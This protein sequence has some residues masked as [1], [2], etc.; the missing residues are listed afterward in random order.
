MS[1]TP[2]PPVSHGSTPSRMTW[3]DAMRGFA[4]LLVMFTHTYTMPQGLDAAFS[5][6][7]FANVA[8]VFQ[9][10]RMPMLMFLSGVLLP[11]SVS[12]PLGTYYRG[13]AERILWPFLVWMVV[14][15]LATGG[16][17]SLLSIEFWRGGAWHLWFLW[18]LMLCYLIGPVIRRVP[19]LV[20]A[21]VLFVLLLEFVS[22]PRH[23]V[24]PL[25][26]GVYFFLGAASAR[27]LPRIRTSPA[28]LGVIAVILM[29]LTVTATRA[30]ALVVA[31]RQPWSVFAALPGIL[32]VLWL[33]PR[34]PRLPFLEF[35]G[36]RSMVLYVAHM[37]VLILAVAAFRD[38]AAVRPVDFYVAIASFT[39]LVPLALALG[40]RRVRWLF[41]FPTAGRVRA[42]P[43]T[44]AS[45][46]EAADTVP[47]RTAEPAPTTAP[48]SVVEPAPEPQP[49]AGPAP[50]TEPAAD[51]PV[52]VRVPR[53][54]PRH[55]D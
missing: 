46:P 38:L 51:A 35:C 31:E 52:R 30:G 39:F 15:A 28:A 24:R 9:S 37:P 7:A 27:L 8:Q 43:R 14:L 45:A 2:T 40:Y 16:P 42:R 54:R 41:E 12:K 25:Y 17:G 1:T 49:T 19:A 34:L 50:A 33:G 5:S 55:A 18:V 44:R 48:L 26:W 4:V 29:V 36:R 22:G 13:K 20:V 53:P 23:W 11:R 47:A 6:V 10:W 32:V 21:V 3:M